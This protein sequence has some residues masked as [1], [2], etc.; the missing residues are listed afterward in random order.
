MG[1]PATRALHIHGRIIAEDL[2]DVVG[3]S[4]QHCST[5]ALGVATAFVMPRLRRAD[6]TLFQVV[7][8][9]DR[10]ILGKLSQCRKP[11]RIKVSES[12]EKLR[13]LLIGAMKQD[14]PGFAETFP[15]TLGSARW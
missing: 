11:I 9:R 7:E 15:R 5:E 13:A 4:C 14:P 1:S 6:R 10:A 2:C 8:F 3:G 12:D